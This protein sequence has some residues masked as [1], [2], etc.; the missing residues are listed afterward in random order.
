MFKATEVCQR[1]P[2][3]LAAK[4][5]KSWDRSESPKRAPP[6][7]SAPSLKGTLK[8]TTMAPGTATQVLE[9]PMTA[10]GMGLTSRRE[11]NHW[12]QWGRSTIVCQGLRQLAS[13]RD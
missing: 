4:V 1:F 8:G 13:V 6:M 10:N 2:H 9:F 12:M 5:G 7:S 3:P 11:T